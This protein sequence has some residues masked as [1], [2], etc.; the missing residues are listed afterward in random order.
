MPTPDF[1]RVFAAIDAKFEEY[2]AFWQDVCNIE[3]PTACKAGVDAVGAYFVKKAHQRGWKTEILPQAVS[4]DAV[5]IT[6][7]PNTKGTPVALSGHMDTVHAVGSFGSPAVR[8]EGDRIYGPGVTDCKGGIVAAF[9]A[10]DALQA[11][12]FDARP[13]LLLLQSD[14]ENGSRTS[15]KATIKWLCE[16]AKGAAAFLNTEQHKNGQV[17]LTRKGILRYKLT[18]QGEAIHSSNCAD[19]IGGINAIAEAAHKIIELERMKDKDG[20]TCNCGVI[21]GGTVANTVPALC[22]FVADIRFATEA[23][24]REAEAKIHTVAAHSYLAGSKCTAERISYRVP[25]EPCER[26]ERLFARLNEI[27]ENAGLPAV[28][29]R[30]SNGG[31]DAADATAAGLPT[32][33]SFGVEGG[34]IHSLEEYGLLPSLSAAAKRLAAAVIGL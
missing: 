31:S 17:V 18:V 1:D 15:K 10:M 7:N 27:F 29:R 28:G 16:Q 30:H 5:C 4:G 6:M 25:M 11:C 12:G 19:G 8:I 14:E 13:V 34:R 2:V 32:A 9:L 3:S 26:N 23:Q 20:I 24:M 33:D 22:T 21:E